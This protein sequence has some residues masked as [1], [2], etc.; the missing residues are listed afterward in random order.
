MTGSSSNGAA[1][2][3]LELSGLHAGYGRY[4]VDGGIGIAG[5]EVSG[6][7]AHRIARGHAALAPEG[8]RLFLNLTVE[9]NLRLGAFHL[10]H[11]GKR[12]EELFASVYEL[13]PVLGRYR[14]RPATALSGGE[15][16]M[17]AI[18]RMLMSDPRILLLDEPSEG[19]APLAVDAVAE[20][21]VELRRQGR[22]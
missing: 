10:R 2:A 12:I 17:V 20:A 3:A 22:S 9:D 14:A 21:L 1:A 4:D 6:M 15:Q 19:L 8:R 11:D 5:V 16:Q 18:G 13:F 7:P